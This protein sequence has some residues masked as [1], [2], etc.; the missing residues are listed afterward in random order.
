MKRKAPG[1]PGLDDNLRRMSSAP[2][3]TLRY[4]PKAQIGQGAD[5]D[6]RQNHG[7]HASK[8]TLLP[9][10]MGK[11]ETEPWWMEVQSCS[12]EIEAGAT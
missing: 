6:M 2:H 11:A 10:T 5:R 3:Q 8:K 12:K 9:L 1:V 4:Y 7:R